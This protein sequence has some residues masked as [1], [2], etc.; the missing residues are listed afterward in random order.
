VWSL[1]FKPENLTPLLPKPP[2]NDARILDARI[3]D[4]RILDARIEENGR[5]GFELPP[6]SNV[7]F[8][9]PEEGGRAR[10]YEIGVQGP[11]QLRKSFR[12]AI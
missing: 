12:T 11:Q 5:K 1:T 3:L 10:P 6:M 4:A 9:T 7:N 8:R 2:L